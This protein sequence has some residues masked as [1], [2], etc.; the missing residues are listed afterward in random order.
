MTARFV[1]PPDVEGGPFA[2]LPCNVDGSAAQIYANEIRCP[3]CGKHTPPVASG[4]LLDVLRKW[5]EMVEHA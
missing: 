1:L 2:V 4:K 5:N 3:K